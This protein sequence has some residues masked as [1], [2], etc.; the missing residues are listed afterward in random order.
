MIPMLKSTTFVVAVGALLALAPDGIAA[1]DPAPQREFRGVWVAT[2]ANIDYPSKPGLPVEKLRQEL[3]DIVATCKRLKLNA[4][5]FQ[6]RPACDALYPSSIEPWS[7]FL[8]GEMGKSPA[9]EFDPLDTLLQLAHAEGME[10]HAWFN[11][12]RAT[13]PSSKSKPSPGHVSNTHPNIVRKYGKYLWLDPGEPQAAEYSTRVIMDVVE[14]YDIDAVHFDDYFYPYPIQ[15]D[16]GNEIPFPDDPSW[17]KYQQ[18]T[19]PEKQLSRD[20]WRRE[21]VNEFLRSLRAEIK[22]S[23]PSVLFGIS[24]FGIYRPGQPETIQGFDAYAKLYADSKLWLEEGVVD[25]LAPQ[26][27]WPIDQK[28]QSFPVLLDWWQSQNPAGRPVWPGL[29]T[30]R[31]LANDE[32][33]PVSEIANQIET[34]REASDSPGHIHFS[35]KA[36]AQN[37]SGLADLLEEQVYARPALLPERGV[38]SQ[39]SS[40]D[41]SGQPSE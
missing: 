23:K 26:L 36:L 18:R 10:V 22:A 14:R 28:A 39:Q 20:D 6:V 1:D 7:E 5:V 17:A 34:V 15:D 2:V 29:Y 12:Y 32:G 11:P 31:V 27:Y 3:V 16:A 30:S 40:S 4:I 8:T 33:W 41:E 35:Y 19:A 21:S 38:N 24:P 37:R 25:Y 13:H 9:G